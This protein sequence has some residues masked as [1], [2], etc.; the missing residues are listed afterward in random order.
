MNN[1]NFELSH[2]AEKEF[3]N[4]VD[5]YKRLDPA[6]SFDFIREF[7]IAVDR[8]KLF[9]KAAQLYLH[10]TMRIFLRRFPYAIV[11]KIYRNEQIIV[12]AIMHLKRRPDY[13][14]VRLE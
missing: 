13:W 12:F 11:Y 4:I 14:E 10:Q 8:I 3:Y 9:P 2:E 7:E 5:Y 1:L 6:L